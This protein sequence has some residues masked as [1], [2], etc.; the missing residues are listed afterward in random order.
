MEKA[1]KAIVVLFLCIF[2]VNVA[3][4]LDLSI[5]EAKRMNFVCIKL[6]IVLALFFCHHSGCMYSLVRRVHGKACCCSNCYSMTGI[7]EGFKILGFLMCFHA[8]DVQV[9]LIFFGSVTYGLLKVQ[10]AY[11]TQYYRVLFSRSIEFAT[12]YASGSRKH[13][14]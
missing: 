6:S 8:K 11:H 5:G 7:E 1:C 4:F 9:E 10:T 13:T 12:H 2:L 3:G 14:W